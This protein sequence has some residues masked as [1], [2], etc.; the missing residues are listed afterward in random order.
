MKIPIICLLFL[1]LTGHF[2]AQ[3]MPAP[4][5][6]F[7]FNNLGDSDEVS[8]AKP[9]MVGIS[10]TEDRFGNA[11]SAIRIYGNEDSY[12]NLGTYS[13]LKPKSGSI[14]IWANIQDVLYV[15]KGIDVNPVLVTRNSNN[16]DYCEAY[17]FYYGLR[18]QTM[19]A[20]ISKDSLRQVH[21]TALDNVKKGQ[22]YHLVL[23]YDFDSAAFY[24]NGRLQKKFRK[25]FETTFQATDSVMVG[26]TGSKKNNRQFCG[27]VDDISFYDRVLTPQEINELY[28]TPNPNK[29]KILLNKCLW[30]IAIL[31]IIT[32]IYLLIRWKFNIRLRK[33]KQQ[34]ELS[35]M[36]LENELRINRA[37]MNPHFMFNAMN[38]LHHY[39][40]T[41]NVDK[42]SDYLVRFSKLIRKI[43]DS[44]MT[45]TISLEQEIDLVESYLEIESLR[46][47]EHIQYTLKTD[48]DVVPSA[49]TIPIMML[50]P[51]I[52]NSVW[53][54]LR[55]KAGEKIISISFSLHGTYYIQCV[56]EDNGTGRKPRVAASTGKKSL[57]TNFVM[58]RLALLN[59]IYGL[60]CKL[61]IVDKQ[62]AQGTIVKIILPILN[63]LN[64]YALTGNHH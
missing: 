42:A 34:L 48:P 22:W 9:R 25:K 35:N 44:N 20:L 41:N 46:F 12:I 38:T 27:T 63:K 18:T 28:R 37:L 2:W 24:V 59:K 36:M 14:S 32:C 43:L 60:D 51:F 62:D 4:V 17:A 33:E 61:D 10:Y 26:V 47:K 30:A 49:I 13:A 39:I 53:H 6:R 56:I 57:A 29:L 15:G 3:N 45:D 8:H 16:L 11:N 5:A 23:T 7:S 21:H 1:L 58:Q 19:E 40:L 31:V 55:D 64:T 50:Q 54:G 52:E